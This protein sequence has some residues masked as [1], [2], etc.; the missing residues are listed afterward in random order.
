M[1]ADVVDPVYIVRQYQSQLL[2]GANPPAR[3]ELLLDQ[4][5]G[6]FRH[7]IVIGTALHAQ[8]ALD[9]KTFQMK[10]ASAD[11]MEAFIKSMI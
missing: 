3:N 1:H 6:R 9:L 7:R 4:P 5:E 10:Q 2:K 11:R 8:R